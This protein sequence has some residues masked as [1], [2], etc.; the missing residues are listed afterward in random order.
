M[1]TYA[2]HDRI[3]EVWRHRKN[4]RFLHLFSIS[5]LCF[6]TDASCI[7]W[8][9]WE[10]IQQVIYRLNVCFVTRE[11]S[12]IKLNKSI[13]C[14]SIVLC[15]VCAC[16]WVARVCVCR[17]HPVEKQRET[18]PLCRCVSTP[19]SYLLPPQHFNWSGRSTIECFFSL[20]PRC[21]LL[22]VYTLN[23]CEICITVSPK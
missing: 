8:E 14:G 22:K 18:V 16:V 15:C 9:I 6:L 3:K 20:K 11:V 5:C 21:Y 13:T 4:P 7:S 10:L 1:R 19:P 17:Q 12:S 23:Y 2:T